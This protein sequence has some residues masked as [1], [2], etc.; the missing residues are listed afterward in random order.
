MQMKPATASRET[1]QKA[2]SRS[3]PRA[4]P[5]GPGLAG[6]LLEL[7]RA[8][9]NH[10]VQRLLAMAKADPGGSA[11]SA[12]VE[13]AIDSARSGG[14][15]LEPALRG[16]MEAVLGAALGHVRVHTDARADQ[17]N[18]ALHA[19]AFTTGSD[20]F[21]RE[22]E[23]DPGASSGRELIA[24]ELVHVV[25]QGGGTVQRK[26]AGGAGSAGGAPCCEECEEEG[27]G[28]PTVQRKLVVGE[29]DDRYEQEADR[30]ARAVMRWE[31]DGGIPSERAQE[32]TSPQVIGRSAD[33]A[34]G[35]IRRVPAPPSG[36]HRYCGFGIDTTIPG[37]VQSHFTGDFDV[38]YTSGCGWILGN[39][40]SS[41]WELY[42]SG[43]TLLDTNTESPLGGYTIEGAKVG[44]GTPGDGRAQWSLWYQVTRSQ[45]WLTDD[46]DAY[47][48]DVALFDV[49][50]LPI[51]DPNTT[52][53]EERGAVIWQDSF[54]PA[55]DGASLSYNFTTSASR[56]VQDSQTTAASLT[57]G[58]D[59]TANVGFAFDGLTAGFASR[60][61]LSA[62]ASVSRTHS[63][64]VTA[65]QTTSKLF[66]QPNLR[67]GVTYNIRARPLFHM[68]DGTVDMI[69]HRNGVISGGA[70]TI[71]GAIRV[72]KGMDISIEANRPPAA[73]AR[74]W[75]C[76]ARCN[77]EG[78]EPQCTGRVEGHSSGHPSEDEACR[79]A[80][81]DAT[82]KAPRN[83]Y[84]RHCRCLNCTQ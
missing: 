63:V 74:T 70:E 14:R 10:R 67:A 23:Y 36:T 35:V 45:P 62:T 78:T 6:K 44:A 59:R 4:A 64:S 11:V 15:G 50:A 31:A 29:P 25:Q 20:I 42:D 41:K 72:L 34:G 81:R 3:R 73:A 51:R 56:S 75:S 54:T 27:A 48:Y 39:A 9:G 69:R 65:S 49:F 38:D 32:A 18:R 16:R 46:P 5:A 33:A 52:L 28:G 68:I 17:L 60:L 8:G 53:R 30:V 71:T 47:P 1:D 19:R 26:C 43:D 79:E 80:K 57:V 22:G 77:V 21:F 66:N 82:Q 76:D 24:H 84:A 2:P 13:G 58:G 83:C 37:F 61:S 55:E 12:D 40:W 7:Q